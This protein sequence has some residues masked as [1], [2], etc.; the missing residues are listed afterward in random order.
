LPLSSIRVMTVRGSVE[1]QQMRRF[2]D[3]VGKDR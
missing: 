2:E 3:V 1:M